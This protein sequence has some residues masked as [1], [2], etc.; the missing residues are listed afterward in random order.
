VKALASFEAREARLFTALHAAEERLIR[1]VQACQHVLAHMAVDGGILRQLRADGP[2]L[3]F[4][5][6][7]TERDVGALPGGDTLLQGRG[8]E[9]TAEQ[10]QA[11]QFPLLL[12]SGLQLVLEGLVA[13][14]L[15]AHACI[16]QPGATT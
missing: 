4:L 3:G 16:F 5:L 7:A 13:C 1:L 8:V 15:V 2:E 10:Q 12:S 9:P 6:V 11:L 14:R